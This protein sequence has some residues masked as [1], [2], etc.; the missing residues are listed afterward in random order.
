VKDIYFPYQPLA[1]GKGAHNH[2]WCCTSRKPTLCTH[3]CVGHPCRS[4]VFE[5]D[6]LDAWMRDCVPC[7][8]THEKKYA[9]KASSPGHNEMPCRGQTA[10]QHLPRHHPDQ[11]PQKMPHLLDVH[12]SPLLRACRVSPRRLTCQLL[13]TFSQAITPL[14]PEGQLFRGNSNLAT[15]VRGLV[16]AVYLQH[17]AEFPIKSQSRRVFSLAREPHIF[18]R[19]LSTTPA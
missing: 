12:S 6:I 1:P 8:C 3:V 2:G 17:S 9:L 4:T 5:N 13:S 11:R 19:P 16:R 7:L 15:S 10:V 14:A 18:D